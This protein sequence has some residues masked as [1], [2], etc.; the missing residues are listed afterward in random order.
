MGSRADRTR[1]RLLTAALELFAKHGYDGTSVS[2]IAARAGVTEMTFFRHFRAKASLL[3][4]DPYD[5]VIGAAIRRQPVGLD[6]ITRA[7]RGVRSAWRQLPP[8]SVEEVRVRLRIVAQTPA[9]RASIAGG[10]AATEAVIA[11]ALTRGT[12]SRQEALIAAG[13]VM[14][15]LNTALLEWSLTDDDALGEAIETALDLLEDRSG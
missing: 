13:A 1:D 3:V 6:P 14:G 8:P 15:A 11:D 5:P 12:T 10:T 9:L 2:E 7:A 4:D